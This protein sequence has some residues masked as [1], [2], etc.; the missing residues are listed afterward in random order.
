MLI[1]VHVLIAAHIVQWW[2][3]GRDGGVRS[4]LSPIEPSESMYTLRDGAVNAGFVVF[5]VGIL[6]TVLLGRWFCGWACHV[7]ALQDLCAWMMK[8]CGVYPKPF[9]TRLLLWVPLILALYMF[10]WPTFH[11][12]ALTPGFEAAGVEMPLWMGRSA[13]FPGFEGHFVVEDFWATF[14]PWYIAVPFLFICGFVTVYFLGGKGFCTYGCPYGGFFAPLDRFSPGRIV[15]NEDCHQCGHCTAACTSNVR[16]H[17]EVRDYGAVVDPGCMKCLDCVSVC[18]NGALSFSFTAP[19]VL[20]RPA[21]DAARERRKQPSRLYDM[22]LRHEVWLLAFFLA[23]LFSIRGWLDMVPL[24]LAAGLASVVT[25]GVWKTFGLWRD[26]NVRAQNIQLKLKGRVRPAG[27]VWVLLTIAMVGVCAW[28]AWTRSLHW[29]AELKWATTL[30][31]GSQAPYT[32]GFVA[33]P[34]VRREAEG[35]LELLRRAGPRGEGGWGWSHTGHRLRVRA[36]LELVVGDYAS[37]ERS[38]AAIFDAERRVDPV[39][40]ADLLKIGAALGRTPEATAA[41]FDG[42]IASRERPGALYLGRAVLAGMMGDHAKALELA[43]KALDEGPA[44]DPATISNTLKLMLQMGLVADATSIAERAVELRPKN[45]DLRFT[46]ALA[47][48]FGERPDD[49]VRELGRVLE[50]RPEDL[51]S[52]TLMAQVLDAMEKP[53]EAKAYAERIRKIH[54]RSSGAGA[55]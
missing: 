21:S 22:E 11:R 26:P 3:S 49:A 53:E 43:P 18:P 39:L 55:R 4:T 44:S 5:A 13:P 41:V 52:L 7:V 37:A 45:T 31:V 46:L 51:A 48:V 17:E 24:L 29:R 33:P 47:Y 54:E 2:Y 42:L 40:S 23:A 34:G 50:R 19:A 16:V 9:R 12:L 36:W 20:K 8:K 32:P 35:A 15:V 25:F 27:W 1:L 6:S 38:I 30:G 10:V 28:S 14:P